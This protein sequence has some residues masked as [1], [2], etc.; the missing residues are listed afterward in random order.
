[1]KVAFKIDAIISFVALKMI[2][3]DPMRFSGDFCTFS[4]SLLYAFSTTIIASSTRDP[5]AIAI[6]PRLM[7][8][9]VRPSHLRVTIVTS[10]DKGIANNEIMVVR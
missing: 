1:M 10:N 7:V 2:I 8:L 6:P 5:I 9:I 4:L 3:L